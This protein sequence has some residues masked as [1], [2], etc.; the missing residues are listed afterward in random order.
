MLVPTFSQC[1]TCA[2]FGNF[3]DSNY[4]SCVDS[5]VKSRLFLD[6]FGMFFLCRSSFCKSAVSSTLELKAFHV[7]A[8]FS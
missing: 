3:V 2:S 6:V 1:R 7:M 8:K 5:A 4:K